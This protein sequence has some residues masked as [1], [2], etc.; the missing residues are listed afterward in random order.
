MRVWDGYNVGRGISGGETA[1]GR[2]AGGRTLAR[3]IIRGPLS[4][5][6]NTVR[7]CGCGGISF[8]KGWGGEEAALATHVNSSCVH[9]YWFVGVGV[10]SITGFLHMKN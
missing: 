6:N 10:R 5:I 9:I 2:R 7:M 8:V 4:C 1:E 3:M